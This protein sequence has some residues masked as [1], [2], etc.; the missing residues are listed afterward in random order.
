MFQVKNQ[1]WPKGPLIILTRGNTA[2]INVGATDEN[3]EPYELEDGDTITFKVKKS[4]MDP[5]S[6]AVITKTLSY[7]DDPVVMLSSS[8]TADLD[9]GEYVFFCKINVVSSSDVDTFIGGTV[10]HPGVLRLV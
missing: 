7:G 6:A 3:G 5:D 8:D 9:L 10:E 4:V 2:A 1:V